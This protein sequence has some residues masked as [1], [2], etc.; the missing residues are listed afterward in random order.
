MSAS[1]APRVHLTRTR[2]VA[3]AVIAVLAAGLVLLRISSG[4][5]PVTV[6]RGAHAGQIFM[7]PCSYSTE[8]GKYAADCGT[9]VVPEN[10]Q[11]PSS[12]LI[13]LPVTRV[14]A[15][16]PH[17]GAPVF[18]LQGG[19]GITNMD[20]PQASRFAT[21]HDVVVVGY[22]GVDGSVRLDCPEVTSALTGVSDL[23]A[24]QTLQAY[25]AAFRSCASRLTTN[26]IDLAGYNLVERVDDMDAARSAL[27]YQKVNLI[28]ESAGTRAAMIYSW[29]YP[30]SI[31]RS[32]MLGVNP[33][34]H[35]LY[36]GATTDAQIRHYSALC[37]HDG[38]CRTR[39][40]DLT[41]TM[42]NL[43]QNLPSRWMFLPIKSGNVKLATFYGLM[44]TT[45]NA[46]PLSAPQTIDTWASTG[47]GDPS[48]M[49]LLSLMAD[50]TIPTS[51]VWGDVA[52][53]AQIDN[54]AA[55]AYY[56]HG[57]DHGSI[58]GNPFTDSL[59]GAGGL[60]KAWP[61]SP[62]VDQYRQLRPSNVDTLLISG[63]VDFATP[64]R[65]AT[66]ELLPTLRDGHQVILRNLGHTA[67]TWNYEKPAFDR[68]VNTFFD[69]GRVD[70]SGYTTRTMDFAASPTHAL[71]AKI[72][73]ASL[74]GLAVVMLA[75]LMWLSVRRRRRGDVG[76]KT[77]VL[78]RAVYAPV[79]GVGGWC[80]GVLV[81]LIAWPSVS[82]ANQLLAVVS[83]GA[84][85]ALAV[86]LA[87]ARRTWRRSITATELVAAAAGAAGGAWLGYHA[88]SGM[89]SAF[90]AAIAATLGANLAVLVRDIAQGTPTRPVANDEA[91]GSDATATAPAGA[92][93]S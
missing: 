57:G 84:P 15:T 72:I 14:R 45:T 76:A 69:S 9:L 46:D 77:A 81:V 12:R 80:F 32:V 11:D 44:Q 56:A 29:R 59:W 8:N 58:L 63:D 7:H 71:I 55:A 60:I 67:D 75:V 70:K 88:V 52:A 20:F 74:G 53:T 38:S 89:F 54:A 82:V 1:N 35:Y 93:V 21:N 90:T 4:S 73:L 41:A 87:S 34:G 10:R 13:A 28:S 62:E 6:P 3:L 25:S 23:L 65:F 86:Y 66:S 92:A 68:M 26:G 16:S 19:P 33:P 42:R 5:S 40:T 91:T 36:D 85:V 27:G 78:A 37:A 83:I 24:K 79:V 50:I 18:Y 22:R 2:V 39:T 47:H 30:H 51:H 49:W 43:A 48:G 17:P 31:N 64:A 61:H